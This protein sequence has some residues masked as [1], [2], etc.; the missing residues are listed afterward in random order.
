[1]NCGTLGLL[2]HHQLLELAQTHIHRVSDAIQPSH[3]LLPPSA[4]ALN[5][6]HHQGLFQ[7]VNASHQVARV[8]E[9]QLGTLTSVSQMMV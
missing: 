5:L 4:P 6:A 2:V 8:L 9:L 7:W 1:M 3:P